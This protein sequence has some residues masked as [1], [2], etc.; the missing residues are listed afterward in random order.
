MSLAFTPR[1][2]YIGSWPSRLGRGRAHE[3][4][5]R[6]RERNVIAV[7]TSRN[8]VTIIVEGT[9]HEWPKGEITYSQVVTLEFPDYPQHPEITY[10][11]TYK[12]G[13]G[14][15]REGVLVLGDSVKVKDEMVFSVS[16]TG[17]S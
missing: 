5:P 8:E 13:H 15:K 17:Q 11:V 4:T 16:R 7:D 9:P 14:N 12:R 10:S 2:K 3:Q 1:V 6:G